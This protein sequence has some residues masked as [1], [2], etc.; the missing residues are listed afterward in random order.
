MISLFNGKGKQTTTEKDL[1]ALYLERL[2]V[3]ADSA[4]H[5]NGSQR[6]DIAEVRLS[7]SAV[8]EAVQP[9]GT[10]LENGQEQTSEMPAADRFRLLAEQIA[11]KC[12]DVLAEAMRGMHRLAADESGQAEEIIQRLDVLSE[13][14]WRIQGEVS[15]LH[16][17]TESLSRAEQEIKAKSAILE[18]DLSACAAQDRR[19]MED[20]G[21]LASAQ[22]RDREGQELARSETDQRFIQLQQ[23]L[24]ERFNALENRVAASVEAVSLADERLE[25]IRRILDKQTEAGAEIADRL[26]RFEEAQQALQRRLDAQAEFLRALHASEQARS[27]QLRAALESIKVMERTAGFVEPAPLP[28]EL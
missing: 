20:L 10:L 7:E 27:S 18:E 15:S 1:R 19:L 8:F 23:S 12:I 5:N 4:Q 13:A 11:P 14:M 6:G 25:G 22:A 9:D 21:T 2:R 28:Q 24:T 17:R 3:I 26:S 16:E